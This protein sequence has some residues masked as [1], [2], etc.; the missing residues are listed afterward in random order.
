MDISYK[1]APKY[2]MYGTWEYIFLKNID[3]IYYMIYSI[4]TILYDI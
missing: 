2:C 3:R 1:N 4:S